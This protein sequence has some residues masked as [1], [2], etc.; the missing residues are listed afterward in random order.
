MSL[1]FVV[2]G[3]AICAAWCPPIRVRGLGSIPLW[4]VLF[5]IATGL[6]FAFGVLSWHALG[7]LAA[8]F[9]AA[10]L[11]RRLT[12]P[13][14]RIGLTVVVALIAV[15]LALHLFPGFH[16]PIVLDAVITGPGAAPFTQ[17][18]N[19]DKA[20]AGLAVLVY[21]CRRVESVQQVREMAG[22]TAVAATA[23]VVILIATGLAIDYLDFDPKFPPFTLSFLAINL[24]F[25]CVAEEAFFRG[26][27]QERVANRLTANRQWLGIALSSLLFGLAHL[28]GGTLYVLLTTVLGFGCAVAYSK[29]RQV[30]APIFVHFSFNAV[31]FLFFTYPLIQK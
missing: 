14:V 8:M 25:T 26:F 21:F 3:L 2:L 19:F 24:L 13:A 7:T 5:V 15:G 29:T 30:E 31:H 17:Y 23:T 18:A 9:S 10:E 20:A 12:T 1:T 22:P 28:R 16:N 11:S 6:G 4:A 27:I